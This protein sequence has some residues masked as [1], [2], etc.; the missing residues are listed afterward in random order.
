MQAW[1]Q[2]SRAELNKEEDLTW[3]LLPWPEGSKEFA[4]HFKEIIA[5]RKKNRS[6]QIIY[7]QL[8]SEICLPTFLVAGIQ[9]QTGP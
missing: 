3:N 5:N 1:H 7:A 8:A 9:D 6:K 2:G 4:G